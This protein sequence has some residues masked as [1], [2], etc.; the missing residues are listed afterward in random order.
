ME[1]YS[2]YVPPTTNYRRL[3]GFIV[4]VGL[5]LGLFYALQ[6]GLARTLIDKV[7]GPLETRII[8]EI[9]PETEEPPPPPVK[10]AAPP[11]VFVDMPDIAITENTPTATITNVTNEKPKVAPPPKADVTVAPRQ[12][13]RRP[14]AQ[15]EYPTMSK[16]LGEEGSV[17][18]LLTLDE[19]GS[20]TDAKV[21]TSS[22]FERLDEAAVK[23][24][25]KARNWKFFPGTVN[26][27]PAPMSFK[28][29]V[30]FKIEK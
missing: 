26:G 22:G 15:P 7:A 2:S 27:K 3:G 4:V 13:P 12:N 8:E 6:S 29:R 25:K 10:L 30:V 5:H 17:V 1:S 19:E 11:P 24:A 20:V 21:D 23:E 28:F 14:I 16:R 9:E 18:L